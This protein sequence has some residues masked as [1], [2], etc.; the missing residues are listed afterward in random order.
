MR[1]L[2]IEEG[3]ERAGEDEREV[4]AG[5]RRARAGRG[6]TEDGR[7]GALYVEVVNLSRPSECSAHLGR[8]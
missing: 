7:V 5:R 2:A 6:G 1:A 3:R 4:A 8:P